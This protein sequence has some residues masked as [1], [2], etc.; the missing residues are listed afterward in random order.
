M[1]YSDDDARGWDGPDSDEEYVEEPVYEEY[2]PCMTPPPPAR[3][4]VTPDIVVADTCALME[5]LET[6]INLWRNIKLPQHNAE[7]QSIYNM[8]EELHYRREIRDSDLARARV[9]I[10]PAECDPRAVAGAWQARL[11]ALRASGATTYDEAS[12]NADED[13]RRFIKWHLYAM[14][15]LAADQH[16]H[17]FDMN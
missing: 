15:H 3:A 7:A 11:D 2:D 6:Y 16:Y 5:A 10:I 1:Y 17:P 4:P 9:R 13:M 12:K 8:M 14:D